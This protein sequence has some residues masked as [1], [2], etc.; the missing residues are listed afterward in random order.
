M[1]PVSKQHSEFIAWHQSEGLH[2]LIYDVNRLRAKIGWY[3]QNKGWAWQTNN[4]VMCI[5]WKWAAGWY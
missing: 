1:V 5:M 2:K 3:I 4:D